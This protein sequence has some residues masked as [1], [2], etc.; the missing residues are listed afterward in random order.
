MA[1]KAAAPS[2]VHAADAEGIEGLS[3]EQAFGE[4]NEI[5]TRLEQGDLSLEQAM[6]LH[7]RGQL[8]AKRCGDLLEKA[9]LRVRTLDLSTANRA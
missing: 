4:L 5:V 8:L 9:E 1:K 2:E 7:A 3:F 6:V